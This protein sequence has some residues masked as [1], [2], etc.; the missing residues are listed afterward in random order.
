MERFSGFL[1]IIAI[2]GLAYAMST[3][4]KAIQLRV[5]LWGLGLQWLFAFLV[6]RTPFEIVVSKIRDGGMKLLG[7]SEAGSSF[8]FGNLGSP[9]LD[10]SVGLVFAFRVLP[11][12]IFIASFF[13]VLYYL[14]VMQ[15]V[16]KGF[17][18]AMTFIMGVSGAESLN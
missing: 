1:G 15:I 2:M 7:Y 9:A 17:A 16:V 12:I 10:N 3:N 11:I 8:V 18:K 4:R 5:V 6:L 14:G 13:S